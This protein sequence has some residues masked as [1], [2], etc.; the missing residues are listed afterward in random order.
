ME[1]V[2]RTDSHSRA[3]G[4]EIA[5]VGGQGRKVEESVGPPGAE[6][7]EPLEGHQSPTRRFPR[8]VALDVG[9][10]VG[11]QGIGASS[12]RSMNPADR[13]PW[14]GCQLS[15]RRAANALPCAGPW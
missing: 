6:L 10:E 2:S 12:L 15:F 3:V 13:D 1:L 8:T 5:A 14:T 9:R 11:L 4:C 7:D